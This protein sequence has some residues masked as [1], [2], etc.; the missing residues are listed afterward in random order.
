L[1]GHKPNTNTVNP[2][3]SVGRP[4]RVIKKNYN[5]TRGLGSASD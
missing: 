5:N 4:N 1:R 3:G 2:H